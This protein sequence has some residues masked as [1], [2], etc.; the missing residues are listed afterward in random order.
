MF[1][2]GVVWFATCVAR[3]AVT[4]PLVREVNYSCLLVHR[5]QWR[6]PGPPNLTSGSRSNSAAFFQSA[7]LSDSDHQ[8]LSGVQF[9][10]HGSA[11]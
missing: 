8:L 9:G 5:E 6:L 11:G 3:V 10:H 1:K 7:V 2:F 4:F